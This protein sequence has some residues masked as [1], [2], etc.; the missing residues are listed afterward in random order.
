[1]AAI[2]AIGSVSTALLPAISRAGHALVSSADVAD[3]RLSSR[4]EIVHATG[5]VGATQVDAWVKNTGASQIIALDKMDVF[6]GPETDFQRIPYGGAGC[7][8][9][10]WEF[11][12]ENDT[13]WNRTA[14][15]HITITLEAADALVSGAAYFV[16]TVA[17]NGVEDS[18]FFTL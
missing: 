5:Q 11:E 1:V 6:F 9:P 10:C 8:A 15:L 4:I 14:T 12:L 2:V 7:T 3:D 17:P 18:K 16:K 13:A